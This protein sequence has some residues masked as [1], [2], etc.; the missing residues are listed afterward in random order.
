MENA[1]Q[2]S[3]VQVSNWTLATGTQPVERHVYPARSER[4][5]C[6][7]ARRSPRLNGVI[8]Y[9]A[10]AHGM[11]AYTHCRQSCRAACHRVR[12][13]ARESEAGVGFAIDAMQ[14]AIRRRPGSTI[15]R[16]QTWRL[17]V[18]ER[19]ER[20]T[21]RLT[22]RLVGQRSVIT[23][24]FW[25][26]LTAAPAIA[27]QSAGTGTE[28][29]TTRVDRDRNG[30]DAVSE[31]VVTHRARSNDE[32]R[33]VI[34]TYLPAPE[35]GRLALSQ[36]VQRVTTVTADGARTVEE[37]AKPNPLAASDPMRIV[38]RSVTTVRKSGSDSY[39]TDRQ[40]FELDGNGRLVLILKQTEH[41]AR[42]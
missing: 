29:V 27:Q 36:R 31:K 32:E 41:T 19:D 14:A 38:Q 42:D 24:L 39:V 16:G 28:T 35:A 33:I 15:R 26:V 2:A 22:R 37:T 9:R 25:I 17:Q 5:A 23:V 3:E 18:I 40:V 21:A 30:R 20:L 13:L 1:N 7:R 4:V 11:R 10:L 6:A 8:P 12:G 34:E